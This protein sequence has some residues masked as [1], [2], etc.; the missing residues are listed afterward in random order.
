MSAPSLKASAEKVTQ[1][2]AEYRTGVESALIDFNDGLMTQRDYD[3]KLDIL[4]AQ[5]VLD[6][7]RHFR[8]YYLGL[9]P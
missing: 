3:L 5:A 1:L 4:M 8:Q 6:L 9:V 2:L 7:H